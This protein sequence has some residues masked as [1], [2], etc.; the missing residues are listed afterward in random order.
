MMAHNAGARRGNDTNAGIKKDPANAES[1]Q[2]AVLFTASSMR[3]IARSLRKWESLPSS[4]L[5]MAT[6]GQ[7]LAES[8]STRISVTAPA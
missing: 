5:L 6:T 2:L 4:I 1:G 3:Y 7:A 8:I